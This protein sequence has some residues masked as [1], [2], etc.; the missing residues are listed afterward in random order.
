MERDEFPTTF[1]ATLRRVLVG[2][3]LS[4]HQLHRRLTRSGSSISLASLSYW[5]SGQRLPATAKAL[6]TVEAMERVLDLDPGTL[7]GTLPPAD[8]H[9]LQRSALGLLPAHSAA[10]DL[11]RRIGGETA[12]GLTPTVSMTD[13]V[14]LD[15]TG[16]FKRARSLALIRATR[17]VD[18]RIVIHQADPGVD[19]AD[20]E[21]KVRAGG[22]RGRE[23][24]DREKRFLVAEVLFDAPLLP[25]ETRLLDY[26]VRSRVPVLCTQYFR[27]R[28]EKE[29]AQLMTVEFHPKCQPVRVWR[30]SRR[31][32]D[33]ADDLRQEIRLVD[34]RA[35]TF[36]KDA[37]RGVHGLG[38]AWE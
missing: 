31:T 28:T 8:L 33:S 6:T 21:F 9:H 12:Y 13:F 11:V 1:G 15:A 36:V 16:S 19:V 4:L 34:N 10:A 25:G 24:R 17:V 20:L 30:F 3:D 35:H 32:V 5:Q 38:W 2:K 22:R 23:V 26:E 18:R 27:S 37:V 14:R 29:Q 7:T